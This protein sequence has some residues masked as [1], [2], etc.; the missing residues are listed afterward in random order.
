MLLREL[1]LKSGTLS[2]QGKV[3]YASQQPFVFSSTIKQNILFG[4]PFDQERYDTVL[5]VTALSE[6]KGFFY[7]KT[8][9]IFQ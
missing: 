7:N 6:V 3:S 8:I 4:E 5:Q 1:P 9:C 2:V